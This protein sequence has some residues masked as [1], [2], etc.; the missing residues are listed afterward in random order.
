MALWLLPEA[1]ADVM[2][3]KITPSLCVRLCSSQG[4][5]L[6]LSSMR[7]CSF[8]GLIFNSLH[9]LRETT[10]LCKLT[11]ISTESDECVWQIISLLYQCSLA[12]HL[13]PFESLLISPSNGASFLRNINWWD[14]QQS[15]ICCMQTAKDFL[16]MPNSLIFCYY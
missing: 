5:K 12:A 16:P 3:S 10:N 13:T 4:V 15:I 8:Q 9:V 11:K 7:S 14:E 6:F 2:Q 1:P